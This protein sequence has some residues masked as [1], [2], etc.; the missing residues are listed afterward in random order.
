MNITSPKGGR[1][2]RDGPAVGKK[3]ATAKRS[4][5]RA[6]AVGRPRRVVDEP[7]SIFLD[8]GYLSSELKSVLDSIRTQ[9]KEILERL[10]AALVPDARPIPDEGFVLQ[11]RRNAELRN[12]LLEQYKVL[13]S[14]QVAELAGSAAANKAAT[15]TRWRHEG[16]IFGVPAPGTTSEYVYPSFEFLPEGQPRPNLRRVIAV[17]PEGAREWQLFAWLT[18]PN[19]WL[20]G[21]VPLEVLDEDPSRVERAAVEEFNTARF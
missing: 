14:T 3:T 2:K 15:A 9:S 5:T 1:T 12:R 21:R 4:A 13:S 7:G 20:A 19:G 18:G 17:F 10:V 6:A 16:R 8:L 11:A